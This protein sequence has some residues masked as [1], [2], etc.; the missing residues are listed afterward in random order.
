MSNSDTNVTISSSRTVN[1]EGA[2][3]DS[4]FLE[5]ADQAAE[6]AAAAARAGRPDVRTTSSE[7]FPDVESALDKAF[8]EVNGQTE[9][10]AST[11][12]GRENG[13]VPIKVEGSPFESEADKTEKSAEAAKDAEKQAEVAAEAAKEAEKPAAQPT[14]LLDSLLSTAKTGEK[15]AAEE[16]P[17]ADPYADVKLRS[18]ASPRTQET[19]AN[20]KKIAQER[21]QTARTQAEAVRKELEIV[22]QELETVKKTSGVV[23]EDVKKELDELKAFRAQFAAEHDP[24]FNAKFDG[25][26][27]SNYDAIYQKLASHGLPQ[28]EVD[29]LKAFPQSDRDSAIENFLEKLPPASRRF[30]EL[31]LADTLVASEDKQKAIADVRSKADT[32][33]KDQKQAPQQQVARRDAEVATILQPVVRNLEFL[34]TKEIPASAGPDER[35]ALEAYNVSA[36]SLQDALKRA[37]IDDSPSTRAEAAIAV[38]LAMHLRV[39]NASLETENASLK[40][41]LDAIK[42]ASKTAKMSR[43]MATSSAPA[44]KPAQ[45]IEDASDA[46][47]AIFREVQ[48]TQGVR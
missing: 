9:H 8:E 27:N 12:T 34:H 38:P 35:K 20:L 21:E 44:A 37:I 42:S 47:D 25:R 11:V 43:S 29:R 14:N 48:G 32:Y 36:L 2:G 3:D 5:A 39:R 17:A 26:V 6:I 15:P 24:E 22:K 30:I 23:P 45:K 40:K 41:E 13:G 46:L 4:P 28:A 16:K 31:K 1:G 7:H 10:G 33:L 18:D 19:F